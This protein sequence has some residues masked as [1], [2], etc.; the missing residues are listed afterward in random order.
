MSNILISRSWLFI[1]F[2]NSAYGWPQAKPLSLL[3]PF[4][5][6][7][8]LEIAFPR[9]DVPSTWRELRQAL[10]SWQWRRRRAIA[11]WLV[12]LI[13]GDDMLWPEDVEEC[14]FNLKEWAD[15][16]LELRDGESEV[17]CVSRAFRQKTRWFSVTAHLIEHDPRFG[18]KS[19]RYDVKRVAAPKKKAA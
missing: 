19:Y 16:N 2:Q 10:L 15:E 5:P 8:S 9:V 11:Q 17:V 6:F 7:G 14:T 4:W 1:A 13:Y 3:V 18:W 12:D